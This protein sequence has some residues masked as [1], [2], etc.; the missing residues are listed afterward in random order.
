[1]YTEVINWEEITDLQ[2]SFFKSGVP[3]I[4][5]PQDHAFFATMYKFAS[6]NNIKHILTGGNFSTECVRNPIEWM[7]YQ[8]DS[9][10]LKDIHSKF[11]TIP[12]YLFLQC[13]SSGINFICPILKALEHYGLWIIFNTTKKKQWTYWC[14]E[15]EDCEIPSKTF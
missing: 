10:Q 9:V 1:M 12:L 4:D 14:R 8:F 3:H 15:K 13:T 7:Y 11:G 5:A 6:E 2:L